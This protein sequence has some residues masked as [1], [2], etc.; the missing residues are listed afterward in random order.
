[1]KTGIICDLSFNKHIGINMYYY[2]LKNIFFDI[3]L[4]NNINDL[5]DIE[6][7]FIGN[8][9]FLPHRNVW[10]NALFQKFCNACNI[11][12]V[13]FS[14][15]RIFNS[16][17]EHNTQIQLNLEK[18]ENLY[19]YPYDVDDLEILKTNLF[20][21]CISKKY[22]QSKLNVQKIDKCVF[23]GS[24]DNDSYADRIKTLKQIEKTIELVIPN[25]KNTWEEYI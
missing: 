13:V 9:H 1:M 16:A 12:V 20:R 10:D 18:F 8:E 17:F 23:L 19:Q 7:L 25:R 3:K 24:L 5:N 14:G 4:V 15:E 22:L 21:P 6:I 2:A 11:K